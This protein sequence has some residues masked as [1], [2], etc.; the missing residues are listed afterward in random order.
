MLCLCVSAAS[1]LIS[2]PKELM[3]Y[4]SN[5]IILD[6]FFSYSS[7]ICLCYY[8]KKIYLDV[9]NHGGNY[10]YLLDLPTDSIPCISIINRLP[11]ICSSKLLITSVYE[12]A[13]C[14][15]MLLVKY[16]KTYR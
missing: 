10:I 5:L 3:A 6:T 16:A 13:M 1:A 4:C 9:F 15:K 14:P 2:V 11:H 7:G 12:Y 8:F